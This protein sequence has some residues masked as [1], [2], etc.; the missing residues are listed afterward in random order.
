MN[1]GERMTVKSLEDK[2]KLAKMDPEL[3]ADQIGEFIINEIVSIGYTG[4]VIGLSGGVDS[5]VTAALAKRAFDK[6][7][8]LNPDKK[9][10][11][12]IGYILPSKLNDP[13]DAQDGIKVA[14]RLE[15]NYKIISIE[16]KL[17]SFKKDQ[18]YLFDDTSHS[19]YCRANIMAELRANILHSEAGF[20]KKLVI[21]TG[22]RDEDFGVGYYTLYGDGAVHMSPIGGLPKRLVRQMARHLGFGYIAD[23]VPAAGLEPGQTDFKDLGYEYE[24][25]AERV[26]EGMLQGFTWEQ[27]PKHR[28][29]IECAKK[30]MEKYAR[31][32]RK[33]KF[34]SVEEMVYDIKMRN[35]IANKKGE[36]VHPPQPIITLTYE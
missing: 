5:T 9:Q 12:L 11:E 31:L 28:E 3:V 22:N 19:C 6:Y 18:P 16:E 29:V 21:G 14:E 26:I 25:T 30:D 10:L 8:R 15:I 32:Y 17:Q 13:K 20:F 36:I 1:A 33:S 27:L 23:K 4:G 7:N 35:S 2:I 34:A 24:C